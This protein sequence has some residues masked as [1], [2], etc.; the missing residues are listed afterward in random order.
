[1]PNTDLI[2]NLQ[3]VQELLLLKLEVNKK[4]STHKGSQGDGAENEW[5]QL[6]REYLPKRYGVE[7]GFVVDHTGKCSEQLDVIIFDPQYTPALYSSASERFFPRE[8]VYAIFEVK[9]DITIE[10]I[11]Y[12]SKKIESVRCLRC[13]AAPIVHAGGVISS[14][15]E[16]FHLIGGLLG[17]KPSWADGLDSIKSRLESEDAP[18]DYIFTANGAFYEHSSGDVVQEIPASLVKGLFRL[19]ASLQKLGTVP[20]IDW[21][22]YDN[23]L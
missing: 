23:V 13:T 20:A 8:S 11:R 4:L 16:P 3:T 6:F 21:S 10:E 17:L 14:P 5:I 15:R 9:H 2:K 18:L 22:V 1:M 12:A 19:L 7:K